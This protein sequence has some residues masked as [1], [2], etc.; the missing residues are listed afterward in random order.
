[1]YA[2]IGLA[3]FV[4]IF[5]YV[6]EEI[7]ID[8]ATGA[9]VT[10]IALLAT[11]F[12]QGQRQEIAYYQLA[13]IVQMSG[14]A[15]GPAALVWL[16]RGHG[17]PDTVFLAFTVIYVIIMGCYL[18][19][20]VGQESTN[21]PVINCFLDQV[22]GI[23]GK[24][25][26]KTVNAIVLSV[27][28]SIILLSVAINKFINRRYYRGSN[29]YSRRPPLNK[30]VVAIMTLVILGVTTLL[31][32]SVE[33]TLTE[34]GQFVPADQRAEASAW[35]FGQIIP[36]MMLLQPLMEMVKTYAPRIGVKRRNTGMTETAVIE[37]K[38]KEGGK[39]TVEPVEVRE[40]A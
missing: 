24:D 12:C 9:L 36:F 38:E 29:D 20:V 30:F 4:A 28:I 34:Y 33:K 32:V 19:Y 5:S 22:S 39:E 10:G 23:Y 13:I 8:F 14:M 17:R 6:K 11:G 1:M 37:T 31:S 21:G 35:G 2:Q 16:K 27:S 7:L 40:L 26:L 18:F 25:A 15:F 3:L